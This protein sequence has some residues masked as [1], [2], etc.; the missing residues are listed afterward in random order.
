MRFLANGY[1]KIAITTKRRTIKNIFP[2]KAAAAN[3]I[4]LNTPNVF[5]TTVHM[6]GEVNRRISKEAVPCKGE[7]RL[8]LREAVSRDRRSDFVRLSLI[9]KERIDVIG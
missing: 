6:A 9:T 4:S 1:I 3:A 8:I 7:A 5:P 2:A